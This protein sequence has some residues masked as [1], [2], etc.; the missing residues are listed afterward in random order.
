LDALGSQDTNGYRGIRSKS[1]GKRLL[2]DGR[3]W[4]VEY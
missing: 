3:G 2:L 1:V 4:E